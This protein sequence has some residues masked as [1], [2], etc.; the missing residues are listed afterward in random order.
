VAA[1]P[2]GLPFAMTLNLIK[3]TD[4][5]LRQNDLIKSVETIEKMGKIGCLILR[6]GGY[7]HSLNSITTESHFKAYSILCEHEI[8]FKAHER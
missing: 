7:K 1:V 4:E 2:E 3:S 6:L 8:D 5:M